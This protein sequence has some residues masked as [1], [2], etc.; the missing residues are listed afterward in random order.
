M[1]VV[2]V[3]DDAHRT[4]QMQE[5]LVVLTGFDDNALAAAGLAVAADQGQLAAR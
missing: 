1:V 4:G 5:G 2:N 3:Q